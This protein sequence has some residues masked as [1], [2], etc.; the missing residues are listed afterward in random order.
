MIIRGI[1][2]ELRKQFKKLCIDEDISMNQKVINLIK[3]YL[4]KKGKS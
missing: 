3:D 1:P 2:E 4:N